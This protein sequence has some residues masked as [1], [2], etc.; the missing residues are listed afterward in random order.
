[1][2]CVITTL[3][4]TFNL[5]IVIKPPYFANIV[6]LL[7]VF[8]EHLVNTVDLVL[9][10]LVKLIHGQTLANRTKPGPSLQLWTWVCVHIHEFHAH[11]QNSLTYK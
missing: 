3:I 11:L 10:I 2:G 5:A 4:V 9:T 8:C 6:R 1:M 7:Q